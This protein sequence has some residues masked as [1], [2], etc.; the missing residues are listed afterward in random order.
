MGEALRVIYP[1]LCI[2][3]LPLPQWLR[4]NYIAFCVPAFP[5][6]NY[7]L[8]LP[9]YY[10]RECLFRSLFRSLPCGLLRFSL[11]Q[12]SLGTSS[13]F[14]SGISPVRSFS[15]TTEHLCTRN[16]PSVAVGMQAM[17]S[18]VNSQIITR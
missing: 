6:L 5:I 13:S 15:P 7:I 18:A 10:R 11:V 14:S 4:Q 1:L 12:Q 16:L 8:C 9:I 17:S 2:C 3:I